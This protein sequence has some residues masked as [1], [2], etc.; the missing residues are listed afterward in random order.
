MH[1]THNLGMES[2]C[3]LVGHRTKKNLN[4]EATSRSIMIN[5]TKALREKY[6]GSFRDFSQAVRKVK[7]IKLTW[8]KKQGAISDQ[9]KNNKQIK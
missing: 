2:S 3:G 4:L 9:K 1:K 8:K 5:G 7:D 6:G